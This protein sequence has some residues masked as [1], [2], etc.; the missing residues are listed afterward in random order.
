[1]SINRKPHGVRYPWK[2]WFGSGTVTL[3]RGKDYLGMSHGMVQ[4]ARQA[5]RRL[6]TRIRVKVRSDRGQESVTITVLNGVT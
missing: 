1:M 3:V 6:G 5:A 2:E 4:S